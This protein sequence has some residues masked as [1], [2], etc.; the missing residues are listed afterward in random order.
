MQQNA[1]PN[2]SDRHTNTACENLP[3]VTLYMKLQIEGAITLAIACR[4][5]LA[6][7]ICPMRSRGTCL[8]RDD[9]N[10]GAAIP[11]KDVTT[12]D[13]IKSEP[14]FA[15]ANPANPIMSRRLETRMRTTSSAPEPEITRSS[16]GS[17]RKIRVIMGS[18]IKKLRT[19]TELKMETKML[20]SK[21]HQPNMYPA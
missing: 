5:P 11:P 20:D 9:C 8:V 21:F 6:P 3:T 13:K 7:R 17:S 16:L 12:P 18:T 19:R 15:S 2:T 4:R 14:W 1:I 10:T